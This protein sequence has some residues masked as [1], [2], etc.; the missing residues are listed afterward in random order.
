MDWL[1]RMGYSYD[2]PAEQ[3][4]YAG[5]Q[6]AAKL[7]CRFCELGHPVHC[8]LH[9]SPDPAALDAECRATAIWSAMKNE[10]RNR[11]NSQP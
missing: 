3:A 11:R 6:E 4:F 5:M 9:T 8:G 7:V 2:A 1:V 10:S